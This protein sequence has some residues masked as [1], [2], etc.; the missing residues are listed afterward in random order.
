[1]HGPV[2]VFIACSLDGFIAGPGDDLSWLPAPSA[3]EDYGYGALLA[4][5]GALLL[6]R[7]TYDVVAGFEGDWHYGELPVL[8]ATTRPLEG[9]AADR[10][11]GQRHARGRCS[12][13]RAPS[14][15]AAS[16]STAAA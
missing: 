3:D 11:R 1:M 16:T 5:T 2:R 12:P 10:P 7:T 8:V 15:T 6:G 9:R 4:Q 14:P 13:R